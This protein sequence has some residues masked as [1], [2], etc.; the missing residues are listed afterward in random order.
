MVPF[1]LEVKMELRTDCY[2][3]RAGNIIK[4]NVASGNAIRFMYTN[5]VGRMVLKML[6]SKKMANLQRCF[7][8]STASS[9]IIDPFI[10]AN[11][12]S[13]KDY[14]P[15]RYISFNDFFTREIRK[16]R[17]EFQI[18]EKALISPSDGRI[19]AYKIDENSVFSI[20][21]S[22][23][24]VDS[25]LKE[26]TGDYY[27]DGYFVLI[28][29]AVDDYHHFVHAFSGEVKRETEIEGFLH[30]VNPI[31]YDYA[32]VYKENTRRCT[33]IEDEGKTYVQMEIGA[34]GVGRICIT[35]DSKFAV[36]GSKKGHFE[37]G[38]SSIALLLPKD[39]Y[40]P[41]ADILCNTAEG[42]ETRIRIGE[43]IGSK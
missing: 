6:A 29:L 19:T 39:A 26:S 33:Y 18:S 35:D 23:Y 24:T 40:V 25:L 42:Y 21:N 27:K 28:R 8:D 43:K 22:K 41:D 2:K 3:D 30:T 9:M 36:K 20:K 5:T 34:M 37:F 14:I 13:L 31:A 1:F 17:R 7:L 38:G 32:D 12:I 15:K 4:K 10:K 16:D 11:N